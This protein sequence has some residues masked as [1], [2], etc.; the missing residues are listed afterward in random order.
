MS[1]ELEHKLENIETSDLFGE[2]QIEGVKSQ[3]SDGKGKFS[4]NVRVF[5]GGVIETDRFV[6][7]DLN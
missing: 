2:R 7:E 5:E 1:F 6:L 4:A 3:F